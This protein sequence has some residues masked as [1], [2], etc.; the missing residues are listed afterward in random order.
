MSGFVFF[1]PSDSRIGESELENVTV[2]C[3]VLF[4]EL[5]TS[6][7]SDQHAI[8]G[9]YKSPTGSTRFAHLGLSEKRFCKPNLFDPCADFT[10]VSLKIRA[11]VI[12][13]GFITFL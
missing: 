1:S 13:R 7:K 3:N 10:K 2:V 4:S 11:R 5:N 12:S 8:R 6:I 9:R